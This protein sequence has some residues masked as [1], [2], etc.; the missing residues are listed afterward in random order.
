M[1]KDEEQDEEIDHLNK[2]MS[3]SIRQTNKHIEELDERLAV[4]E[5]YDLETVINGLIARID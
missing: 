1:F 4:I 5:E 3:K 2:A